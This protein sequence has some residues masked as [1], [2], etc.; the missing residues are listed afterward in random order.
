MTAITRH[1]T[2]LK[3]VDGWGKESWTCLRGNS[4]HIRPKNMNGV[5]RRALSPLTTKKCPPI[6]GMR[7]RSQ[8][9]RSPSCTWMRMLS[10]STNLLRY[11]FTL[12]ADIDTT[13]WCSS[14]PRSTT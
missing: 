1:L 2:T 5:S 14:W 4:G 3:M 6:T 7:Y 9:N 10:S 13:R 11:L 8:V 12:V